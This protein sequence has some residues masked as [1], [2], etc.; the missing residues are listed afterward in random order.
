MIK[1]TV[2][3]LTLLTTT[4]VTAQEVVSTQGDS[5]SNG[6]GSIDFTI[7]EV[8]IN[9]GTDGTNT[10]TQGFHQTNWNFVGLEDHLPSYAAIIFPNPTE[11]VLNIRT[12]TFE[13]VRYTLYDAQGKLVMQNI[14]SSEQTPIQVSQLAPGSYSLTLNND[15][16][17][18]KTFKL[19]KQ[20]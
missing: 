8:I 19:I 13:N 6:T 1:N 15:T 2:L 4:T 5:Y 16:Q 12:S 14:L 18:L 10:L 7:G 3:F 9:T 17:N 20:Q 11:D